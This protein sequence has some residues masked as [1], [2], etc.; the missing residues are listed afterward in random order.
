MRIGEGAFVGGMSGVENDVIP[1][2]TVIGNRARLG[3]LNLVGLRRAGHPR[4]D[5]HA[6]RS[7]YRL[8]FEG[9]EPLS[10]RVDRV[11]EAHAGSPLVERMV[12]FIREGGDRAICTP[13]G[14]EPEDG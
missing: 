5:I 7:A 14:G 4:D 10:R 9:D 6:L 2:G 12:A 13:R 8:L 1:F 11:A 3:G